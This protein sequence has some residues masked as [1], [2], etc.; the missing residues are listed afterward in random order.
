MQSFDSPEAFTSGG[1]WMGFPG[2]EIPV[3]LPQAPHAG[4]AL[5]LFGST[6][7]EGLD[8][9]FHT[10]FPVEKLFSGVRFWVRA[11]LARTPLTVAIAGPQPDYFVDR[12]QGVDWPSRTFKLPGA[13]Q[14]IEIQFADLGIGP[15]RLSPHS[16]TFGAVHFIVEPDSAYDFWIDDFLLVP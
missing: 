4:S 11:D 15:D 14:Q 10:A 5:H 7:P 1:L 2:D 13:W 8:V 6:G 9:F 16:E 3:E 12:Q